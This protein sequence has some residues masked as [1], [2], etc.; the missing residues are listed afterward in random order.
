MVSLSKHHIFYDQKDCVLL[1]LNRVQNDL[2]S[3]EAL[4]SPSLDR[5]SK[6]N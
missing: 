3:N 4:K 5:I 6:W 1:V 2:S